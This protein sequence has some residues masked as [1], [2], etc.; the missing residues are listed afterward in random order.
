MLKPLSLRGFFRAAQPVLAAVLTISLLTPTVAAAVPRE[1]RGRGATTSAAPAP[2]TAQATAQATSPVASPAAPTPRAATSP[3]APVPAAVPQPQPRGLGT[4]RQIGPEPVYSG[5]AHGAITMASNSVVRCGAANCTD[6]SSNGETATWVKIDPAAPG[7]TASSA[8]ITLPSGSDVLSARLYWQLNPVASRGTSGDATKANQVAIKVPGSST[9][10]RLTADTYDWFDALGTPGTPT[11]TAHAGAKDVT[12]LVR[13][14]GSG[15]YTVADLQACQGLSISTSS[16]LGCWGG[17]SLVVAYENPAE[18]LRYLQVWDGYQKVSGNNAVTVNLTGIKTVSTRTPNATL[19]IT[20]GDGDANI[21]R[22]YLQ[23]GKDA[24]SLQTLPMPAPAIAGSNQPNAF[25]SRIDL[26]TASGAGTNITSRNPAPVNNF[27][28]DARTVDVTGKVPAGTDRLQLKIGTNGDAIYP[29]TVWLMTDAREPDLHITK[30]NDPIG[31]TNDNPPGWVVKGGEIT[32]TLDVTNK[33]SD[34]T[35]NDLDTA[36]NISVTDKL[37]TGLSY[38]AGSGP[39]CSASGQNVT[40]A[41]RNL[42]PGASARITFRVKVAESVAD[43]TKL[44][45]TAQLTF[46]GLETGRSQERESNTVRNTVTSPRYELVK[47]VDKAEALPGETLTYTVGIRNTGTVA[48]PGIVVTD[49]LPPGTSYVSSAPSQGT[50]SGTGPLV[51]NAGDLAIG[52]SA[53]LQVKV[54]VGEDAIGKTLVNRAKGTEGPP[55]IVPPD[56]RCSDDDAAACATTQVPAPSY[57][58]NKSVDKSEAKPGEKV[59]YTLTVR[60]TGRVTAKDLTVVDDLSKVLDD[61]DYNADVAASVGAATYAA[62]RLTWVGTLSAQG[63]ATIT[64]SVTVKSPNT[65]D[66]KLVNAVS[67]ETP[68]GNCPPGSTDPACSQTTLVPG[69]SIEKTVDKK[70]ASPGDKVTYTVTVTNTGQTTL[71]GASFVDDMTKVLDDA[72]Y[73]ADAKASVG[74]T[75]YAAPRLTWSGD[76]KVGESATV[77]YSVTVR[78]PNTGDNKLINLVSSETP[79]NT[80][81]PGSTSP[82]CTTT[83]PVSGFRIEKKSDPAQVNPGG[84]VTYTVTVS[85]T[86]QTDLPGASFVDDLSKVLDD[87]TYNADA[88]ASAGTVAYAAPRL[89]WTGD[90]AVGASATVKYSVRVNDPVKGDHKLVN[91]VSSETPGGNCPP[92]SSDPKC[93]TTT[94]VSGVDLRKEVDKQSANPG[95]KV[96]YTVTMTNTGQT[97]LVGATFTDDLTQVLDDAVYNA[98]AAAS[99][100]A[101]VYAAPRLTWTGDLAVGASATVKYSVTV[102]KPNTGDNKLI[103]A[104]SSET[105]GNN[106]KPSCTTTTPV[107]GLLIVKKADRDQVVP[108]D[109]VT[110][111]VTVTNTGQTALPGATFT[112][113]LTQVLDDA[114]YN[115]DA[116]ASVGAVVYA[117]PRL[118]WTGDLAVGAVA[119]VKYSVTVRNPNTGD[120]KLNNTVTSDTPGGN[121]P[122]GSTDPNCTSQVPGPEL[123]VKKLADKQTAN[124]G[125]KVTYTVTVTNTGQ[126]E[127]PAASFVD[128]LTEVL[129]DAAYNEDASASVGAAVFTTPRLTWTGNLPI[130]ASA[131]VKYSVTVRNPITGDHRMRNTVSTSTPGNCPPG[132]QD[133]DCSTETPLPGL[134]VKKAVD[135]QSANP[136]DKVTY[137]VTVTNTGRTELKG[138]TFTDDLSKVLD[139]AVYNADAAATVGSVSYTPPRL[140]WTGDL[141]IGV[142]ATITYSVTVKSPNTGDNELVNVVSSETPGGNCPPGSKDPKCS[143]TTPVSGVDV[144]KEVDRQSANPGDKVTYTVTVTNT[145]QT[146]LKGATFTDDLSKVLDDAAYNADVSAS[147]GAATYAEPRLTWTGD[148]AIGVTATIRYS[149]TVKSPNTGDNKLINVVTSSGNCPPGSKDPKCSTTTPVSGVDVRKEVDRQSANPGD[150][151]TYTVTVTNTG[152]TELKGATFTDDLSKVLDDAAYN[153]DV[154]ASVGAA[155]YAEPRLTWTGDLAI[156]AVA[157]VKYSVTVRKPNTGDNKLINVVTSSGN[158]PPGSKDPKCG[159]TTPVSGLKIVKKAAPATVKPGDQVTYTVTVTNTGQTPQIGASFVDDLSKV[160]DDAVYNADAKA[161]VGSVAYAPPKLTWTGDLQP[162]DTATVTYSVR[163]QDPIT[164]DRKLVNAVSSETPGGNCPPGSTDPSC[165]TTTPLPGLSIVKTSSSQTASPGEQVTY[166]VVVTNT[167]QTEL[168]GATFT[169]DLSKVLDD[170]KYNADAT[171]SLGVVTYSAPRLTW[172]GDL[173]IGASATVTYSVTVNKPATGDNKLI[174][175]VSSETPGGNCPPGSTDPK[176]GTT[177]NVPGVAIKKVVDKQVANPGDKVTYT[178]TVTNT[179][180]TDLK[181]ATFTDDLSKVLDD[182]V[183]NADVSASV[184]AATYAEP[185]LTWTGD[186]KIGETATVTYSVT[187]RKPNKGDHQLGN[188]VSSTTPGGNCPPGSTDPNCATS[189]VVPGV[190]IVKNA[191]S[192]NVAPGGKVVYTVTVTNTGAAP[193][194]K[195][196][197]VDDLTGVLDDAE[198]NGDGKATTGSVTYAAPKLTWTGDLAVGGTATITYSVTVNDPATGD[199]KLRNT[200]TSDTPGG[201]CQPGD[202]DPKCATETPVEPK[203]PVPPVPPTGTKPPLASTG[204]SVSPLAGVGLMLLASGLVLLLISRR[205]KET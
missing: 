148:L 65:G 157:T 52:G 165:T 141:A 23:I 14:A 75:T 74:T 139:D 202:E 47:S 181:G 48:A 92:G 66:H 17:W 155:T 178:V 176:C 39:G 194:T 109:K 32:Y 28:Y 53:S 68:G 127:L 96:T 22:D 123:T 199:R 167:G 189:T 89:T 164:G 67:S 204:A 79:G 16:N 112:D 88:V 196:S 203:P 105:P 5:L 133:P 70:S 40:C 34:G 125:D 174:N 107:S 200:V 172:V 191:G 166:T 113:D 64:Y 186:L 118:T 137:T 46:K 173:A 158:C 7:N 35:V 44:D 63:T 31:T 201:N 104:V 144:R 38:V 102:R 99:V 156:G 69:M 60:N 120:K 33:R 124:P 131:T 76:L 154:S 2:T 114:V 101:V 41:V 126:T 72:T 162:G 62:P 1:H 29:Q 135:K 51:W 163:V 130:G 43:G 8:R 20:A 159:T 15:D 97:V 87:A 30:A 121:C 80:C 83:T 111:T 160:L 119:T 142:T 42:E 106:C 138:A 10:Q 94:P 71:V 149:V 161:T 184:G 198:Y 108:G 11:I 129:D 136:G 27:G 170:A 205:R 179:G 188:V 6:S 175:V 146:E 192:A 95:D 171:A 3:P 117:A 98:D 145:G 153:A 77:T 73:N 84:T 150:K 195:V 37:P 36:T 24:S 193:L 169:D 59:V 81:P 197:F 177:T 25:S 183:Y 152:Q 55:G 115:A 93:S 57:T 78:K 90:L 110:Y 18:P 116:A 85:N 143:T 140:T 45:N 180:Q 50:V 58:V 122:P 56:N 190:R 132:S 103:N 4:E 61:A 9:Y 12:A 19:G 182:A 185:R 151:V 134:A 91:A 54:L 128:D 86:G 100:G 168:K 26:V 13:Q 147:V 49:T 21:D 187:V 82:S